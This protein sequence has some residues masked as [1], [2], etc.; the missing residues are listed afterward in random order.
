MQWLQ[1]LNWEFFIGDII[2]P[3]TTFVIGLFV[4]KYVEKRNAKSSIKGNT[5]TVIQNSDI[6]R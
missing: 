3:I 5:N 4:G 6:H 1:T 2:I